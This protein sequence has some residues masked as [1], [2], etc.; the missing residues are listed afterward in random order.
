MANKAHSEDLLQSVIARAPRRAVKLD[1]R[2]AG[3]RGGSAFM[4]L[5]NIS[6]TGL[7]L[8]S[9]AALDVDDI[10]SIDLPEAGGVQ[11]SVIWRSGG[12]I[13]CQFATPIGKNVLSAVALRSAVPDVE[14]DG[15][16]PM[17]A[18]P[19]SVSGDESFGGRLHRLR[20]EKGLTQGQIATLLGVSK[21][22][23]WAWEQGRARPVE[24]RLD[25]LAQV[26][27]VDRS[28][29]MAEPDMSVL[30]ELLTRSKE[31]IAQAFGTRP[32]NV[33]IMIEL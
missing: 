23:V 11:A 9:E 28:T 21:P 31:Q 4:T 27:S 26:L 25:A 22:T 1:V 7:L 24:S 3:M 19:A 14:R 8:H 32:D 10:I 20:K 13:G 30:G 15:N 33:R 5:Y 16:R 29:L 12:L 6:E 17:D 2:G 18:V